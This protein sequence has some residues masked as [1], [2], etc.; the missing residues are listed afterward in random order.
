MIPS[1]LSVMLVR[2]LNH[3]NPGQQAVVVVM[4]K[5]FFLFC[6]LVEMESLGPMGSEIYFKLLKACR[7]RF[8]ESAG[9]ELSSGGRGC[10]QWHATPLTFIHLQLLRCLLN[11]SFTLSL[12]RHHLVCGFGLEK[13]LDLEARGHMCAVTDASLKAD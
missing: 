2:P 3:F 7:F 13:L 11:L 1:S 5:G 8:T 6:L 9:H 12:G 10:S 4:N